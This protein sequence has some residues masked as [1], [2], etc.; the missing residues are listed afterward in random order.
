MVVSQHEEQ[1]RLMTTRAHSLQHP[2]ATCLQIV[3]ESGH[4]RKPSGSRPALETKT[5]SQGSD[6]LTAS[7]NSSPPAARGRAHPALAQLALDAAP[8]SRRQG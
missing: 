7:D 4:G 2:A 1:F 5:L 6:G 8:M 3:A